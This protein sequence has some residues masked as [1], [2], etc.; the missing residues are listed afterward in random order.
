MTFPV[1]VEQSRTT[2]GFEY[3]LTVDGERVPLNHHGTGVF[4][5]DPSPAAALPV[6]LERVLRHRA[7]RHLPR[8]L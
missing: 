8:D 4:T 3:H 6:L 7:E 1:A 2:S 5:E